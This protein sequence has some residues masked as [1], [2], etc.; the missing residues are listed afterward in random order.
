MGGALCSDRHT[1]RPMIRR[2]PVSRRALYLSDRSKEPVIDV[3][4][5]PRPAGRAGLPREALGGGKRGSGRI[6]A[7]PGGRGRFRKPL[8]SW[9]AAAGQVGAGPYA[10]CVVRGVTKGLVLGLGPAQPIPCRGVGE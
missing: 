10:L 7:H 1:L 9:L 5:Q 4:S 2:L 3:I 8:R 6:S